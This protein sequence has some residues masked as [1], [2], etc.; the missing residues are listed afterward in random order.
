MVYDPIRDC[1][2]P[3]PATAPDAWRSY[4]TPTSDHG[5]AYRESRISSGPI[6]PPAFNYDMRSPSAPP[7]HRSTSGGLRGL[8]N[9]GGMEDARRGSGERSSISSIPEEDARGRPS[10]N[11]ILNQTPTNPIVKSN[12]GSSLAH[13]SSPS[14]SMSSPGPRQ[15]H[16]DPAGFLTPATPA[17]AYPRNSRSPHPPP[18][19]NVGYPPSTGEYNSHPDQQAGPSR[20]RQPSLTQSQRP[21]PPPPDV[22]H[23]YDTTPRST[24]G[25]HHLPLSSPSVSVSPRSTHQSLPG[26]ASRPGS[27]TSASHPYSFQTHAIHGM[28]PG[29]SSRRLS[30]E[31]NVGPSSS[32]ENGRRSAVL[33]R[34][35]SSQQTPVYSPQYTRVRSLSPMKPPYNPN[36]MS[37][38]GSV[39]R[40]I[41]RDE[42]M[43]LRQQALANN[44]LRR[45]AQKPPPAWA[46]PSPSTRTSHPAESDSSY[47]PNLEDEQSGQQSQSYFDQRGS[48]VTAGRPSITPIP[49]GYPP[50][51]DAQQ[52]MPTPLETRSAKQPRQRKPSSSPATNG[53]GNHLK[54]ASDHDRDDMQDT[55][56]R[57]VDA[58]QYV[59]NGNLVASHCVFDFSGDGWAS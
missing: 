23:Q 45:K 47:F 7:I 27:A 26:N 1:E 32:G 25:S 22:Y 40:P 46:A 37:Q 57:R 20:R 24:P 39:L 8:L 6:Q 21:M 59:G 44:P 50:A 13:S 34:R 29:S 18:A 17:S 55:S 15:H 42:I 19:Y 56:R 41:A 54:R 51:F 12:S 11:Q 53:G 48:A 28:S 4:S 14:K 30:I 10:I 58:R 2:V 35:R 16:L 31:T 43:R 36:R 33:P 9:E 49:P 5:S 52:S 3:S 38:P